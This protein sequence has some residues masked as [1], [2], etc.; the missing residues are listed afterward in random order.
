MYAYTCVSNIP[1]SDQLP[2]NLEISLSS[3]GHLEEKKILKSNR[4]FYKIQMKLPIFIDQLDPFVSP[5]V[6][7]TI[8]DNNIKTV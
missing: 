7:E 3:T 5:I 4:S 2:R 6:C 1:L 8:V